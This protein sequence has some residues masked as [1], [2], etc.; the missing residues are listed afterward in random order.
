MWRYGCAP[1]R[2]AGRAGS[3]LAF[4]L[5][6]CLIAGFRVTIAGQ[7]AVTEKQSGAEPTARPVDVFLSQG[8]KHEHAS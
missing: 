6:C 7:G 3:G 4:S 2:A 1:G 5:T 8:D